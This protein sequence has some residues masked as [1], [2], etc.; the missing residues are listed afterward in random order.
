MKHK[1][2]LALIFIALLSLSLIACNDSSAPDTSPAET[3]DTPS[4]ATESADAY[5][6]GTHIR[7]GAIRGP[8]GM[9][10][11]PL[12]EWNNEGQTANT[13]HFTIGGSPEDMTAGIISGELDIA[14]V[15]I[16]VAS[17]L[18]NRLE[19]EVRI[20]GIN[21]LGVLFILDSSDSIHTVEDLRAQ[22]INIIGQGATPQFALEHI[23][24]QNGLEPG[25]DVHIE[26]NSEPAELASLMV[27]GNVQI[28]MLPQPFVTTVLNRSDDIRIALDL[29]EEWQ[30]ANPDTQFVQTA[31]VVRTH[32]LE[33][34]FD[35]VKLFLEDHSRSVAYVNA[36]PE[37][38]AALMDFYDI[39]PAEI[40]AQAIP[41]SNLVHIDGNTMIP[42]VE[43]ILTVL[44]EANP[45]AVGGALPSEDFFFL[46]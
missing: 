18:Y 12:M 38:S 1:Q 42:L 44:Y 4:E 31:I 45:Q 24:R 8:S 3:T 10:I 27:A 21:T 13:Y 32:F 23:L 30:A 9:S 34:H 37:R 15:P 25:V 6:S 5:A 28:G 43:T 2:W 11:A 41:K 16:N 33:E 26:F 40:A 29:T 17:V 22:T 46:G 19:G 14:A 35:A 20:I 7:V 39:I 36:N